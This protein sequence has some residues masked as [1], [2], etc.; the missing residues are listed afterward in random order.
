M[1]SKAGIRVNGYSKYIF[2]LLLTTQLFPAALSAD[3]GPGTSAA[4]YLRLPV[5]PKS[6]AMGEAG[7]ALPRDNFGWLNNPAANNFYPESGAGIF[8]SQWMIDTYYD[9]VIYRQPLGSMFR[10]AAALTYLSTPPVQGYDGNNIPLGELN[11]NNFQ[12]ILGVGFSPVRFFGAGIN[13]KYFQEKLADY[14]GSGAA[15]DMGVVFKLDFPHLMF[16][17][18]IQNLGPRVAFISHEEEL[19]V[20]TRCGGSFSM[21]QMAGMANLV[22]AADVIIPKH[23]DLYPA[24]GCEIDFLNTF[25]LR[26]GYCGEKDRE[27]SGLTAGAGVRLLDRITTDYAWT[28]YGDLGNFHRI[29]VYFSFGKI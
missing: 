11:S 16:G 18:S 13:I 26:L 1:N 4:I 8:H 20:I 22:L 28:P 2:L 23:E 6:I 17:A 5:N 3:G 29:S 15:V 9:N 27:S 19:P 21:P 25:S 12:G 7:A 24:L 14:T 10:A